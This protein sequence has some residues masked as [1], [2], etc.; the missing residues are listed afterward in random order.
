MGGG[1]DLNLNYIL[2]IKLSLSNSFNKNLF[3]FVLTILPCILCLILKLFLY[4]YF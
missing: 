3:A 2:P 1:I 4:S